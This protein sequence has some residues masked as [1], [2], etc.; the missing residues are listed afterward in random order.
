[1]GKKVIGLHTYY[2]EGYNARFL[3][4]KGNQIDACHNENGPCT[5]TTMLRSTMT[6]IA[7]PYGIVSRENNL[8]FHLL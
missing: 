3:G 8:H 1:M 5:K 6:Q 7:R 2:M 4:K